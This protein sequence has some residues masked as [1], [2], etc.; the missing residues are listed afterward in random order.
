MDPRMNYFRNI[1]QIGLAERFNVTMQSPFIR[2]GALLPSKKQKIK[3]KTEKKKPVKKEALKKA[4]EIQEPGE[5][6]AEPEKEQ[7]NTVSEKNAPLDVVQSSHVNLREAVRWSEIL[8]EPVSKRR[9]KRRLDSYGNQ[10]YAH[11]G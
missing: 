7:R 6:Q 10:G 11:R 2:K 5:V 4:V 9:R 3:K 8:G 1:A